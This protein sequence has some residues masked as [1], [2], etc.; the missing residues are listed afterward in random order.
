MGIDNIHAGAFAET[1]LTTI[2]TIPDDL[3]AIAYELLLK[4]LKNKY[5]KAKQNIVIKP[6]IIIRESI[7]KAK[8]K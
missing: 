2:D 7:G 6:Q 5:F 3:C 8:N 4:K 1:S